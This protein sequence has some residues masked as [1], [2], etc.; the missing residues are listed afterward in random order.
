MPPVYT[1]KKWCEYCNNATHYTKHCWKRPKE[2]SAKSVADKEHP[3]ALKVMVE[4]HSELKQQDHVLLVETGAKTHII[5][6]KC[7]FI[8]FNKNFG[9][10]KH[11]ILNW[12]MELG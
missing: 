4:T 1:R 5:N 11:F 9:E 7:K 2:H 12:Q 3:F 10:Y 8:S 6:D